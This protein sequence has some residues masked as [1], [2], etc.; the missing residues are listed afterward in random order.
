MPPVF[1][2]NCARFLSFD[3]GFFNL[4]NRFPK[5]GATIIWFSL[6]TTLTVLVMPNH[7]VVFKS[8]FAWSENPVDGAGQATTTVFVDVRTTRNRGA[9]GLCTAAMIPQK[10]PSSVKVPPAMWPASGWPI[11]PLTV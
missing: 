1:W 7:A 11:V 5:G 2:T 9:P 3:Y 8:E 6:P 10:P 4:K